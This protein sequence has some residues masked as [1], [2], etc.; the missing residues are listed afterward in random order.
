MRDT[1][2]EEESVDSPARLDLVQV[3]TML[4]EGATGR[5]TPH[6]VTIGQ[7]RRK[8]KGEA[9]GQN[10]M[11]MPLARPMPGA[12]VPEKGAIAGGMNPKIWMQCSRDD[13]LKCDSPM[14]QTF[15]LVNQTRKAQIVAVE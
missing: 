7:K 15:V 11:P 2:D 14:G 6:E 4:V 8:L 3:S 12:Q 10:A 9:F 5:L 13:D 1:T